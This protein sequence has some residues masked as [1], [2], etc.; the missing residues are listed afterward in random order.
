MGDNGL[1]WQNPNYLIMDRNG[2]Y[3][4]WIKHSD[5]IWM[6]DIMNIMF[7]HYCCYHRYFYLYL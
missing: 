1:T 7:T 5:N 6:G 3:F 4:N 2:G